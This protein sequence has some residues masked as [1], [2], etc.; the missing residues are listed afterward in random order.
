MN[1]IEV[2]FIGISLSMDAFTVSLCQGLIGRAKGKN[3]G[4]KIA[5]NF[6]IFQCVMTILGGK[7]G[8][9]LSPYLKAYQTII[10]SLIFCGIACMMA[11]EGWENRKDHCETSPVLENLKTVLLLGLATSLDAFFI[12]IS[13]AFVKDFSILEASLLIGCTTFVISYF[14]YV[15]G[16]KFSHI[17][18]HKAYYFGAGLLFLLGL[19]SYFA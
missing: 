8:Q 6:G 12:G 3:T 1:R 9:L 18:Q 15:L 11:K 4:K 7:V 10:P 19:Y 2:L 13:F 16:K 5:L 14:G 17:S